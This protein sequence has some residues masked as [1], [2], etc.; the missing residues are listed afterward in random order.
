MSTE[1][2]VPV[3]EGLSRSTEVSRQNKG[4][5]NPPPEFDAVK[6]VGNWVK[7]G[8]QVVQKNQPQF[9]DGGYKADGW[10]VWKHQGRICERALSNGIYVLMYRPRKLQEAIAAINGNISR[11]KIIREHRGDTVQGEIPDQGM[12]SPS[13]VDLVETGRQGEE[14]LGYQFNQ[15]APLQEAAAVR[16]TS[17]PKTKASRK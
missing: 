6:F 16:A 3:I 13:T 1:S 11:A 4:Q 5:L 8:P 7:K 2:A 15:I 14:G 10:S 12:V 17:T 9:L